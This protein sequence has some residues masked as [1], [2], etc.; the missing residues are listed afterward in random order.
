MQPGNDSEEDFKDSDNPDF[1]NNELP[2][3]RRQT[4]NPCDI[5]LTKTLQTQRKANNEI[6][7]QMN[8]RKA[9]CKCD[10]IAATP[11]Q[12]ISAEVTPNQKATER[13]QAKAKKIKKKGLEE[14][15]GKGPRVQPPSRE[16][17]PINA[18]II[19]EEEP[20]HRE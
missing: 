13:E 1:D 7:M 9:A 14:F 11:T 16:G 19:K 18:V 3:K 17:S 6:R 5:L 12:S 20:E 15:F 8:E 4:K 10:K 2:R